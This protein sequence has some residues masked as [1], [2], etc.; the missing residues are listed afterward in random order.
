[1]RRKSNYNDTYLIT[2]HLEYGVK[3]QYCP[4]RA[5]YN[6]AQHSRKYVTVGYLCP[7][8]GEITVMIYKESDYRIGLSNA[9]I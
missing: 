1:M 5:H 9:N 7:N 4:K 3:C 8:C 6:T 2:T